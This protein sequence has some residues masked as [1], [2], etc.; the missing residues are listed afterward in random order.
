M[1][2]RRPR[3]PVVDKANMPD[4]L[5]DLGIAL[6]EDYHK[7]RQGKI[8]I[9]QARVSST[10]AEQAL[11]SVHLQFQGLRFLHEQAKLIDGTKG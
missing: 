1:A 7:L 5:A 11:R 2:T 9:A 8:S 3:K 10:L 4:T 6:I